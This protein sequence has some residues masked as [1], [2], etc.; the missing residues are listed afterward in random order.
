MYAC[1]KSCW[2]WYADELKNCKTPADNLK[3]TWALSGNG[4]AA[5]PHLFA[6]LRVPLYEN[7]WLDF[8]QIPMGRSERATKALH[9]A[10]TLSGKRGWTMAKHSAPPDCWANIL[11]PG[12]EH[13]AASQAAAALMRIHHANILSLE[14]SRHE[15]AEANEVWEA[16]LFLNMQPVR[17]VLEYFRRDKYSPRSPLGRHLLM[18]LTATLPDNK[19]V[20]DVHNPLR[21]ASK[22]NNND[23]LA[24][25]TIQDTINHSNV[26]EARG[27]NHSTVVTKDLL[28]S[29]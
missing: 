28:P 13:A 2:D 16:C 25:E 22:G 11:Q 29:W 5:E 3:R 4:W 19:I 15:T 23:K 1:Q 21:L 27:I 10:W 12:D 18:G 20:E 26:L 14:N 9:K 6:T 24:S 8:M 17:V 7:E